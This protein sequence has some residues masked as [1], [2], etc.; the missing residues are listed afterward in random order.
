MYIYLHI[1]HVDRFIAISVTYYP[2]IFANFFYSVHCIFECVIFT[3]PDT[4][5]FEK[6]YQNFT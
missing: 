6:G 3:K 5:A 2:M 4:A 1:L